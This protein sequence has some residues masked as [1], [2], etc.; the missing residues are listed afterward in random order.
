MTTKNPTI[1]LLKGLAIFS[2]ICAHC[3]TV[4]Q[5]AN[6]FEQACSLLLHNLGTLG[7]IIFFVIS[8]YLFRFTDKKRFLIKKAVGICLP[9]IVGATSVYLYIAIRNPPITFLDWF[10]F[11]IGNG[12]YFYYLT[13]LMLLY[14]L[15]LFVPFLKKRV[16]LVVMMAMTVISVFWCYQ[17]ELVFVTP[18]LNLLNWCGYFAL[19]V[20]IRAYQ[21]KFKRVFLIL[22]RFR[23]LVYMVYAIALIYQIF[24]KSGGGYW[25]LPNALFTW[26]GAISLLLLAERASRFR[27]GRI[28]KLL[29]LMG[30]S[31]L[32]VYIWHMPIAGIITNIFSRQPLMPAVLMRPFVVLFVV[33]L[34][35]RF[36][37]LILRKLKIA[38]VGILFGIR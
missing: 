30:D 10:R 8:G 25:G 28:K 17:T 35:H 4:P 6:E 3:Y 22:Y 29:C 37:V 31:S 15:F 14:L 20:L 1:S 32:F 13:I 18:Y 33:L 5:S 16:S 21:D 27:E 2:V 7:V 38:Q 34:A 26:L 24:N 11:F 12:S 36:A 23:L 9:W 19:G